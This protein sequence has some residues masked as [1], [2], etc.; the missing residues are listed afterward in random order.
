ML[1][2]ITP[3]YRSTKGVLLL[4]NSG[5][6]I[7]QKCVNIHPEI[8]TD[9][10]E[11]CTSVQM[12]LRDHIVKE[13]MDNRSGELSGFLQRNVFSFVNTLSNVAEA[14]QDSMTFS[15]GLPT[16]YIYLQSRKK[17][18]EKYCQCS[19]NESHYTG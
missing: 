16:G 2:I 18:V 5:K 11:P 3:I 15:V 8:Q 9:N 13:W 6:E 7:A 17:V 1:V 10:N 19:V 14:F 12:P 4:F